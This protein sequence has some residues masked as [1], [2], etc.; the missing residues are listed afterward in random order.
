MKR[1]LATILAI[2]VV[3]Y[4]SLMGKD[5][6]GTLANL[7]ESRQLLD[8]LALAHGGR[9][10]GVAGDSVLAEFESPVEAVR[11]SIEI[12][13]EMA[14]LSADRSEDSQMQ[15]RIGV[16]L[17]DIIAEKENLYGDGVNIAA[18]LESLSEPGGMCISGS[19]YD[20]VRN[21]LDIE[22]RDLG[23]QTVKNIDH[24]VQAWGWSEATRVIHPTVSDKPSIAVLPFTNMSSDADQGYF[25]DG[26]VEDIITAL[27]RFE[28]LFVIARNSSFVYKGKAVDVKQVGRDLGVRYVLEGSVRKA[29]DKVRITGQL[30]D[31]ATGTHLWA[32]RFDGRLE[33]V[34][35]LQDR[36][37]ANVVGAIE[38]TIRKAEIER[39]RRKPVENLEAYDLYLRALPHIYAI[40]PDE[41]LKAVDLL[42]RAIERDPKYASALAHL[43]W[44]LV[45]RF[46]RAWS[47][48]GKDDVAT[49]VSLARRALAAGSDEPISVVLGG[50]VLV[51]LRQD[52]HTGLEA[53]RR[54]VLQNPGS[55]FVNS[56]AA[57]ALVFGDEPEIGL[58][59][60]EKAM[61][62]GPLD[63]NFFSHLIGAATAHLFCGR[64]DRA[65]ELAERSIALNGQWD[66]SY[67]FLIASYAQ[68]DRQS[69]AQA[70]LVKLLEIRPDVTISRCKERLP[71][72]NAASLDMVLDGLRNAGL[73]E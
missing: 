33:D 5:E 19:V 70:A 17:G 47:P 24:P 62:L 22:F 68:L 44:C 67:I 41:N 55:G 52:Y 39:A 54:A 16:N 61:E 43:G 63:T 9:T 30:I 64:P 60:M 56:I 38:P 45:Q 14:A 4:S 7:I 73:P 3:G 59:L 18:R 28:Q 57:Y 72:R 13:R 6:E 40:R 23:E 2:D 37:T 42:N 34:F 1:R 25:V 31:G 50:F 27:S 26:M 21:R 8:R 69:D 35:D 46:T 58:G 53:V 29:G 32:D 15:L 20:L 36:I 49:A 48:V 12:Q 71:I 51:A 66:S 65:A 10:F 11:C